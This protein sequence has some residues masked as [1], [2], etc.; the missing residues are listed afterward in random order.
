MRTH[1]LR[2]S[3]WNVLLSLDDNNEALRNVDKHRAADD[4]VYRSTAGNFADKVDK[5]RSRLSMAKLKMET[6]SHLANLITSYNVKV[7]FKIRKKFQKMAARYT[8]ANADKD[9]LSLLAEQETPVMMSQE[10]TNKEGEDDKEKKA[11][12][13]PKCPAA[14]V[15]EK[16]LRNHIEQK[17]ALDETLDEGNFNPDF[18]SSQDTSAR[19]AK[20]KRE[21]GK[22]G[23]SLDRDRR[24]SSEISSLLQA[25]WTGVHD[26]SLSLEEGAGPSRATDQPKATQVVLS[27]VAASMSKAE[28]DMVQVDMDSEEEDPDASMRREE[29]KVAQALGNQLKI[30]D[31]LL[32]I[33]NAKL[34]EKEGT[35]SELKEHRPK[36]EASPRCGEATKVE[37]GGG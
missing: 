29:A 11:W 5:I 13:C 17:H 12:K 21:E 37:G 1:P 19:A 35:I 15:Y 9:S 32:H 6:M 18:A 31:D 36:G 2:S 3:F 20:R 25:Q 27:N 22:I 14:Y 33:R 24:L 34:M 28:K 26:A 23:G 30:K 8:D 7:D 10:D 16:V 4:Q